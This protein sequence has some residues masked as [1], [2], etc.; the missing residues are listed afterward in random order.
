MVPYYLLDPDVP[1][2]KA[3]DYVG[4]PWAKHVVTYG[5]LVIIITSTYAQMFPLPRIIYGIQLKN[6]YTK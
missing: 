6:K 2:S 1:F 3:F 4:F 5:A